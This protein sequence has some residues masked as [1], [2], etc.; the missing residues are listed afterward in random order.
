MSDKEKKGAKSRPPTDEANLPLPSDMQTHFGPFLKWFFNL[1]FRFVE[2]SEEDRKTIVECA[3]KGVVVYIMRSR[4]FIAFLFLNY[5]LLKFGLPLARFVN[6]LPT[7]FFMSIRKFREYRKRR[8][9]GFTGST[10]EEETRLNYLT[11]IGES[12]LIFLLPPRKRLTLTKHKEANYLRTL[13]ELQNKFERP[14]FL[15]PMILLYSKR[16]ESDPPSLFD[17]LFRLRDNPHWL[18]DLLTFI[19][20]YRQ[21]KLRLSEPINLKEYLGEN[22]GDN[23]ILLA[24]KLRTALLFHLK[25]EQE[26][27]TGPTRLRPSRI[28]TLVLQDKILAAKIREL[29]RENP[30]EEEKLKMRAVKYLDK[31]AADMDIDHL[32]FFNW[33][34]LKIWSTIKL[35]VRFRRSQLEPLRFY[36]RKA[37]LVFC[38][39][40]R[41][42]LDYLIVSQILFFCDLVPPHIAAG[43]NLAFWPLGYIFRKSGAFF[44]RRTFKGDELYSAVFKAYIYRLLRGHCSLEF[45]L[46]G[47]RSRSGKMLPPKTGL[48]SMIYNAYRD[49]VCEDIYFVPIYPMYEKLP[50]SGSHASE[51]VGAQKK[52]ETF[53]ALIRSS[54]ILTKKFGKVDVRFGAPMSLKWFLAERGVNIA[55]QDEESLRNTVTALGYAIS[56]QINEQATVN[57]AFLLACALLESRDENLTFEQII[58]KANFLVEILPNSAERLSGGLKETFEQR[59]RE[60][61]EL[62][63]SEG[64]IRNVE[65]FYSATPKGRLALDYHRNT[66]LHYYIPRVIAAAAILSFDEAKVKIEEL[67][68]RAEEIRNILKYEFIFRVGRD[69]LSESEEVLDWSREKGFVSIRD[70]Y[71]TAENIEAEELNLLRSMILPFIDGYILAA[72]AMADIEFKALYRTDF[73]KRAI[74]RGQEIVNANGAITIESCTRAILDN[75]VKA[76]IDGGLIEEVQDADETPKGGILIPTEKGRLI[77]ER[78]RFCDKLNELVGRPRPDF[79]NITVPLHPITGTIVKEQQR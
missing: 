44:L 75:A 38:P 43:E 28:K 39:A 72:R 46:E 31:I 54:K 6:A 61:I 29:A 64:N 42:H 62:H 53:G 25:R 5:A 3:Q 11:R 60:A 35:V 58:R 1:F 32:S 8:I 45:F 47:G 48:L 7:R 23:E 26:V 49:G 20:S 12:S 30:T 73:V 2:F 57:A 10:F 37:P 19:W 70:G 9:P 41:S 40:H 66:C 51:L 16:P 56:Y 55:E 65:G 63:I 15:L 59:L 50:D 68:R 4:S 74:E 69:F 14:I 18:S 79:A 71:V 34:L 22:E 24:R 76:L 17:I 77:D 52:R 78:Q 36:A 27:V 13:L 21:A 67:Y 33:A